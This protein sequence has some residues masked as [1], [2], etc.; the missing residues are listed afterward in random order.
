M[1]TQRKH[2][3][4]VR[5]ITDELVDAD[6][7]DAAPQADVDAYLEK[8]GIK[9][10]QLDARLS[11]FAK[12]LDGRLA[13]TRGEKECELAKHRKDSPKDYS[14]LTEKELLD[15]INKAGGGKEALG[16]AARTSDQFSRTDLEC[17]L[18]DLEDEG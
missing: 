13:M 17:L 7:I 4:A 3:R 10:S 5:F 15:L 8:N 12:S 18:R 2:T 16:L 6:A 11:K 9:V 14:H 1:K